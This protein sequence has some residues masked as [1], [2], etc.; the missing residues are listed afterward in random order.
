[1]QMESAERLKVGNVWWCLA[2]I[3][4]VHPDYRLRKQFLKN[5]SFFPF[6]NVYVRFAAILKN[7]D[8]SK[9]LT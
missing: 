1:M 7:Q 9:I 8:H 4:N 3:P 2:L 6:S 5:Q